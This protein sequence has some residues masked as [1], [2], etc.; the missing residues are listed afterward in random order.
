[1]N[2][3]IIQRQVGRQHKLESALQNSG[4]VLQQRQVSNSAELEAQLDTLPELVFCPD[5]VSALHKE[6]LQQLVYQLAPDCI[7][8]YY[9]AQQWR[10]LSSFADDVQIA[11]LQLDQPE[12]VEQQLHY[13]LSYARLQ[14]EFRH[15]KHLLRIVE[16]RSQWLVDYAREAV[17]Y[18]TRNQHLYVNAAYLSLFGFDAEIDAP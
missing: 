5:T 8:V 13:L 6:K 4:F 10:G 9:A 7:V 15:C 2:C 11:A 16:Q 12:H 18:I 14:T 17:A 3:L 1:M